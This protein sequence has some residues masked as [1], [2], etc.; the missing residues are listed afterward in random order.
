MAKANGRFRSDRRG[1]RIG[2][3]FLNAIGG[4]PS[5]PD[6]PAPYTPPAE[7]AGFREND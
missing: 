7:P 5:E 2:R 4:A 6:P 1:A 3:N